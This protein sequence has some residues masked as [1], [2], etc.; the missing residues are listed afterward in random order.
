[1]SQSSKITLQQAVDAPPGFQTSTKLTVASTW[2]SAS[3]DYFT[4][5]QYIEAANTTDLQFGLATAQTVALS[6]WVKSSVAGT[7]TCSIRNPVN[8]RAYLF[9]YSVTTGWTK[10]TASVPGDIT[11]TWPTGGAG[12]GMQVEFDLGSG[13]LYSTTTN[14]W[15]NGNMFKATG[16]TSLVAQAV[17]STMNITGVQLELGTVAT[18]FEQRSIG[19]EMML[20]QRYYQ[21][22]LY[23]FSGINNGNTS[24]FMCGRI[25]PMRS[26]PT[27]TAPGGLTF[28]TNGANV[29]GL[30]AVNSVTANGDIFIN[31][32]GYSGAIAGSPVIL[33]GG[34][35]S[36]LVFNAEL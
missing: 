33:A 18:P 20:C 2:A 15:V 13:S 22:V 16:S 19:A 27:V 17:N 35:T 24:G 32:G 23:G 12:K 4:Y 21:S 10:V 9:T 3:T 14:S 1:M 30:M 25:Y 7:Y 31:I 11:G 26:A 8:N 36:P 29:A 5:I 28:Y 34:A 6:F